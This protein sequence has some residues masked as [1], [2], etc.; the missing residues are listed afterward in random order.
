MA[1]LSNCIYCGQVFVKEASSV[2]RNCQKD[3][4]RQFHTVYDYIKT[5]AHRQAT[6]QEVHEATQVE[7]WLIYKWIEDRRLDTKSFPNMGYPC[8]SCGQPIQRGKLCDSCLKHM[9]RDLERAESSHN[10]QD[11]P[12]ASQYLTYHTEDH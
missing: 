8:H 12:R 1:E 2:C 9:Q 5:K 10:V 4:D 7:T 11:D 3:I 6:V